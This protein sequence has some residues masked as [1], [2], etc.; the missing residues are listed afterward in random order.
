[1]TERNRDLQQEVSSLQQSLDA[2][3]HQRDVDIR[4]SGILIIP[5]H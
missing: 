2:V 3:K 4:V 1:L 5:V